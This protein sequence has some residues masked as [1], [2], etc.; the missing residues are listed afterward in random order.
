MHLLRF[1]T[2]L[3]RGASVAQAFDAASVGPGRW[4]TGARRLVRRVRAGASLAA[5]LDLWA[6]EDDDHSV[7]VLRDALAISTTTGGS[8]IRAVDAVIAAVRERSALQRE[9]RALASQARASA[10]M[11]VVMPV[12]FAVTVAVL[13]PR[14]RAFS[15]GSP[16]G[17]GCIAVGLAL[18]VAGAWI[19]ARMIRRVA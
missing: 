5:A 3:E 7:G 19:M 4:S 10:V 17:L 6:A 15:L 16:G 8:H 14:V 13:D 2:A 12:G 1:R 18:D 11:L 9:V